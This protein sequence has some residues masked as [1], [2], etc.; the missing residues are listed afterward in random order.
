MYQN[1]IF[2]LL[3]L[4]NLNASYIRDTNGRGASNGG[5]ILYMGASYTRVYMVITFIQTHNLQHI[6]IYIMINMIVTVN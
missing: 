5:C 1:V 6:E 2:A 4:S 3:N